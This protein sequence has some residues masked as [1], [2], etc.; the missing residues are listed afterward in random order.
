M[1]N[2]RWDVI[3]RFT[4]VADSLSGGFYSDKYFC[5][6]REILRRDQQ[7]VNVLIQV[8]CKQ[9]AMVCGLN[10]ALALVRAGC[11]SYHQ[12]TVTALR[13]GEWVEPWETVLTIE[14]NYADFAHLETVYLGVIARGSAVA[15]SVN[16]VVQAAS[17][18]PVY[19]FGARFDHYLTQMSDGYAANVGGIRGVS[20]DAN[21]FYQ[22]VEGMGTIPHALIAAYRGDSVMATTQFV[23]FFGDAVRCIAL[24]DWDN[25]C[26]GTSLQIARAL[27]SKLWGVR[28]D[29]S[30]QLRDR[31]VYP[32][33]KQSLGVCPELV[34]KA[35]REFNEAGFRDLKIMV[36]GGFDR[37]KIELFEKLQVP[38]DAYGVGSSLLKEKVDFTADV[39]LVEGQPVA[40]V[41]GQYNPNPRLER[42]E[43]Q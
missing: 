15:T 23:R 9:R 13:D 17:G 1:T 19:Y 29:T 4:V 27:G 21:G 36:S 37:D 31:S 11:P 35:R 22:N 26:I 5:R 40:K 14:G 2:S 24:V 32:I 39:V 41:G 20:T 6:A 12:L 3:N 8:F 25:D 7:R 34:W 10:E 43:W 38:V 30:E 16:R 18:K 33:G 28:F 42:I